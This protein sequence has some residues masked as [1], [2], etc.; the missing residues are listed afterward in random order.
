MVQLA[1]DDEDDMKV[2]ALE[3]VA[4]RGQEVWVKVSCCCKQEEEL[5]GPM[6]YCGDR[7]G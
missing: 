5:E 7:C 2:K 3:F 4:Q 1:K 6:C